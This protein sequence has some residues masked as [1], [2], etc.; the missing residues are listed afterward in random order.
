MPTLG[1]TADIQ[2]K[3]KPVSL[4]RVWSG[5]DETGSGPSTCV[6]GT[7]GPSAG[8]VG[9]PGSQHVPT[10]PG[11]HQRLLL[12]YSLCVINP[13]SVSGTPT[14]LVMPQQEC[15]ESRRGAGSAAIPPELCLVP[16]PCCQPGSLWLEVWW[17]FSL[18][19]V[20]TFWP[21]MGF[22]P[23]RSWP[24]CEG[25]ESVTCIDGSLT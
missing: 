21:Y 24:L 18:V 14:G 13:S 11:E 22:L 15:G 2:S 3:K 17:S 25:V 23:V 16:L 4:P 7:L 10:H 9:L 6:Q 12:F 1:S 8:Q 5:P 20:G 19:L